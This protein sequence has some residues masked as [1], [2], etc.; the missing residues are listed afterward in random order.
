MIVP[1]LCSTAEETLAA[2]SWLERKLGETDLGPGIALTFLDNS[3]NKVVA[4]A[5]WHRFNGND[6]HI[7]LGADNVRWATKNN[8]K[9]IVGFPFVSWPHVKRVTAIV[10]KS[11][12]R[13][14]KLLEGVGWGFEGRHPYLFG[15]EAGISYG[16]TK[17]WYIRS[18]WADDGQI[19]AK[20]SEPN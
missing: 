14:R 10:K 19:S 1:Y 2:K 15:N 8:F 13:V 18:K 3:A 20:A 16:M 11:N 5:Y 9:L 17:P 6:V 12:K 7:S 4:V